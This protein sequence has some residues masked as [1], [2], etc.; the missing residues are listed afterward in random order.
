MTDR[1]TELALI[2]EQILTLER[3]VAAAVSKGETCT[4]RRGLL[5]ERRARLRELEQERKESA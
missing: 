4:V 5:R 2:Q 1:E 3:I